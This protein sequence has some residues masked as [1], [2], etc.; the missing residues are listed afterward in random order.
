MS[1]LVMSLGMIAF[2]A[3]VM[4]VAWHRYQRHTTKAAERSQ[5]NVVQLLMDSEVIAA[6]S[7]AVQ[8]NF[9]ELSNVDSSALIDSP[10]TRVAD[11]PAQPKGLYVRGA[12][13]HR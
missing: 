8:S 6:Q 13:E 3:V 5:A 12:R 4:T 2:F 11:A 7:R 10:D 9:P 1:T